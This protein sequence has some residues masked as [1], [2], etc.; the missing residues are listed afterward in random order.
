[1]ATT[2]T[3]TTKAT[4]NSPKAKA[5]KASPKATTTE[6]GAA[7]SAPPVVATTPPTTPPVTG[8][9]VVAA[10]A[11]AAAQVAAGV[12]K[13][14]SHSLTPNQTATLLALVAAGAKD[15]GAAITHG[16]LAAVTGRNK[17]NQCRQLAA[18]GLLVQLAAGNHHLFYATPAG[19]A[20]VGK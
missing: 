4:T 13:R 15:P 1:M 16:Q 5:T 18:A 14:G 7:V 6:A 9:V 12:A 11:K 8:P 20:A 10:T 17:G 3:T 2:T 19:L